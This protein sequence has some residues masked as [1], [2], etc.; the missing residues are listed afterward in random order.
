MQ[1]DFGKE[2]HAF[3][4][5]MELCQCSVVAS[6]IFSVEPVMFYEVVF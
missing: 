4:S 3:L 2:V 6:E 1:V 5:I